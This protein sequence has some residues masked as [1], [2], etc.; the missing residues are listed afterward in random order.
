M[1]HMPG[2]R[3]VRAVHTGTVNCPSTNRRP[4]RSGRMA[5]VCFLPALA[6]GFGGWRSWAGGSRRLRAGT[7]RQPSS[8]T[9]PRAVLP[10]CAWP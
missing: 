9:A 8:S 4:W 2:P 5:G 7:W 1:M 3:P 6:L 10:G